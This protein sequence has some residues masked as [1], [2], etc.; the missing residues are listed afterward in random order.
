MSR[1]PFSPLSLLFWLTVSYAAA[2]PGLLFAPDGWY[3]RID[4]PWWTPPDEV[5]GPVWMVLYGLMGLGVYLVCRRDQHPDLGKA[6]A[7]FALQL[8]LNAAYSPLLFGLHRL[9]LALVCAGLLWLTVVS[10]V[11][12]FARIRPL[13]GW[14]Q[15]PYL[16][17]TTYATAL[18]GAIWWLNR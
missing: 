11:G 6:L 8:L 18:S 9:D 3:R 16:L 12:T 1:R 7:L 17:W 10:M 4:K 13:A 2:L 15:L 14:L 5:F